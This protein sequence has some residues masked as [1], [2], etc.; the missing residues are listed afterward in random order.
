MKH[1]KRYSD[2]PQ[3]FNRETFNVFGSSL[4]RTLISASEL[5]NREERGGG[6]VRDGAAGEEVEPKTELNFSLSRIHLV[7][8]LKSR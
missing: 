2:A 5:S 3:A 1:V 6:E 4:D 7:Y 8:S